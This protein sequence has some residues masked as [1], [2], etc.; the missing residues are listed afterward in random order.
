MSAAMETPQ[1]Y[2]L[3]LDLGSASLGWALVGLNGADQ[4]TSLIRSGVRIFEPGVDGTSLEIEQGKD[5]SKAVE[6]R[7]A[8]L[9]RRQLRRRVAR[10]RELFQYLQK[11]GLLP[12]DAD[13]KG[14][15]SEQRHH[16]LN[17]LD[18][19]LTATY[20]ASSSEGFAN[21]PLYFLRK[22]ALDHPLEP[23]ELGR[24]LFHLSQRRGFKSNR[25][26]TKKTKDNEDQGEVKA[27]IHSLEIKMQEAGARTLGEYFASLDPHNER[28]RGRWTARRMFEDE[29]AKIWDAQQPHHASVLTPELRN[30]ISNLLFFQRPIAL[31]KD[32]IGPCELEPGQKRA[33][34]PS[35][36][37]Q[38]FRLLQ[39]VN[40]TKVLNPSAPK[41]DPLTPEQRQI[42]YT[43]LDERG[44]QT[45]KTI[46]KALW[47]EDKTLNHEKGKRTG[48]LGNQTA[49]SMR[50]VF[51][52]R[53]QQFP[54]EEQ[55]KIVADWSDAESDE[56]MAHIARN[57]W[58]LDEEAIQR[59]FAE[60]PAK[61]YCSLSLKAIAKL[62]PVMMEG[63]S[64]KDA[65]KEVYGSRNSGLPRLKKLPPVK[66][67]LP[68]L[69]NPAVERAMTELR[70]VINAIVRQYGKPY[71]IRIE[72]A[73]ELKKP[74]QERAD[75]TE[76]N[77]KRERANRDT[78]AKIAAAYNVSDPNYKP[79]RG[80][81]EKAK[82][83][84]ECGGICPYTGRSILFS[85]LFSG[86]SEFDIEHIIPRS[87][88]PDDSFQNKTL[89]YIPENRQNKRN[90]TPY[91]AYAHDEER[92]AQIL[93]RVG[94]WSNTSKLRR[95]KIQSTEELG[96]FSARQLNDTR[97]AS[98]L[99]GRLLSLLYGGDC[100]SDGE[101]NRRVIFASSGAVTST[102]RRSWG[103]ESI[104]Q[105]IVPS[106]PGSN[107][108]KPRTDHRHHAI[109]AITIALTRQSVIQ[110]MANAAELEPW[111]PGARAWRHVPKPWISPDFERDMQRQIE[112]MVVSH[113]PSHK[114]SG[115]LHKGTNYGKPYML[116]GKSTI[117]SRCALS[118]L[119]AK[120]IESDDV[121]VDPAVRDA[122]R[123][124]LE[125]IGGNPKLFD[126]P[127]NF[128]YLVSAS[129]RNIPIKKVRIRE[130]KNPLRVA[131]GVRERYVASGGIHHVELFVT[132]D[133]TRR[134]A[135]DSK[136]VQRTEAYERKRK[137]LPVVART[138][139]DDPEAEFLFS[140]SNDDT[141]EIND[142]DVRKIV[143]IKK[144]GENK[145]IFYVPVND[146]HLDADQSKLAIVKSKYPNTLKSLK[147]R[148]VVVDLLG[149]VHPAND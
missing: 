114:I 91:E 130:T 138:L 2:V 104:L 38:R 126:K 37:A 83:F 33:P 59:L 22:R 103:F 31:Q 55:D 107:R 36:L 79:S 53:W 24:V 146:A 68:T 140:L 113:R 50:N 112:E 74:R 52:D 139:E 143:R 136:V 56:A 86:E 75:A 26:E 17:E 46:K 147:P 29:F 132:R 89:C 63:K 111:Q 100:V 133:G 70:K 32:L 19:S 60:R 41:D 127:D 117:H 80:D 48:L 44:D 3:G 11:A 148:K 93:V 96:D 131:E 39:K 88:Y 115:E 109:D 4:P 84:T 123:S 137:H 6:R 135:W 16:L 49:K 25:K 124:K 13:G 43:L 87:R 142:G 141:M 64:F 94:K 108:G 8:R 129:G 1:K 58:K 61:D 12:V 7:T 47:L 65:E 85:Q 9:Q 125:E 71:E 73:R 145:Q 97:Y 110:A 99:A 82:L 81:L 72:L 5:Q 18:Q 149:K 67:A 76:N 106:E 20:L 15:S 69:R 35:L 57:D 40:D 116:N 121:I 118:A 30:R 42:L 77:R 101:R 23:Y 45:F 134:E 62:M 10:Q 119:S 27:G 95:F 128:P 120:D 14:A 21:G 54:Q 144:S 102:L 105:G 28:V 51:G 34:W 66:K 122:V 98:V 92:W 90:L 78:A